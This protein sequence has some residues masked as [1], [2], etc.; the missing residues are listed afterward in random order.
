MHPLRTTR[1]RTS[2]AFCALVAVTLTACAAPGTPGASD[3]ATR[4]PR[5]PRTA[6]PS[7]T[8][9]VAAGY[10]VGEIPPVPLF[11]LPDLSMLDASLSGFAIQ[12]DDAVGDLAGVRVEPQR[13]DAQGTSLG[14]L[15]AYGDGSGTLTGPDG[16]VTN[17]GDGSGTYSL[18]GTEVTVYGDGSGTYADGTTTVTSYGDGSGTYDDGTT[19][20]TLYGDGSGTWSRG[21]RTITNY[22]DGSGVYDDGTVTIQN[23]GDGSGA[24]EGPGVS[25]TNHGDGT[26]VVNGVPVQVPELAPVPRLGTF[27]SMGVLAPAPSC[28]TRIVLDAAVLFDFGSHE[29]RADAR[30]TLDAVATVLADVPAAGV[31]GHTD[32][33]SSDDFNQALSERRA[34]A[35][36]AALAERGVTG[37]LDTVGYG[38]SRPV[39]PDEVDGADNPAGR[40][41]NRR[42]EIVVPS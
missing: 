31:E 42:V 14:V 35:V 25:I 21:G 5:P 23:Y 7:P 37:S 8:L 13:C 1:R 11:V 39:A 38:E 9:A 24:Y 12:V 27:P 20:V 19:S 22:G 18:N 28:G 40:Q 30:P 17:Y 33:V 26:G 16:T 29:L 10:D 41:L 34:D 3:P 36:A 32:S 2:G 4:D 15:L 6:S